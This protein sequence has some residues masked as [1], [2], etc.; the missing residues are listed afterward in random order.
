MADTP[1]KSLPKRTNA[2][3]VPF[4]KGPAPKADVT[5][6]A[7]PAQAALAEK[8]IAPKA[9]PAVA[10]PVKVAA[11]KVTAAP[12]KAVEAPKVEAPV[13][14]TPVVEA[15]VAV[16]PVVDTPVVDKPVVETPVVPVAAEPVAEIAPE[17]VP[18]PVIAPAP[19]PETVTPEPVVLDTTPPV[20]AAEPTPVAAKEGTFI[21]TDALETTKK[22]VADAKTQI[23]SAYG[24]FNE[25]SKA[26]V[27]K[28]T[29]L[30]EEV[31]DMAKGNVEALVESSKIASKAMET[32]GQDAAEVSRK[33]FEKATAT[34]KSFA[35][36]K[37]PAEF[38]QLQS[39]LLTSTFDAMASETSKNSEAM[40]KLAGEVVQPISS[41]IS[42][43]SE[44]V[45][46]FAA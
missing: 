13:V 46:S 17:P 27:E 22:L 6:K 38:F 24:E 19:L 28:S 42:L 32:M 41:R 2:Q 9:K 3:K 40:L 16:T 23:E 11:P 43:M 30:F 8:P 15:P 12:V 35:S 20:M 10:A 5:P 33:Q 29:K 26:A 7:V 34:M 4:R 36:V 1:K 39:E 14:K 31:S 44:K 45:K 21:M 18:E 25:K 37:S